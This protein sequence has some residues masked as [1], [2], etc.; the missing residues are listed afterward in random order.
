MQRRFL[1]SDQWLDARHR[2]GLEGELEAMAYLTACGWQLE[3]HRFRVGRHD[4]DL[5]MRRRR[6]VAF[7]EVKTRRSLACGAGVEAVGRRK[8]RIIARVAAV[9]VMRHGYSGDEYRFDVV[10]VRQV[11]RGW[12]VMHVPDAFRPPEC[13][14]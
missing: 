13:L 3:A 9:W 14:I 10:E 7:V 12:A 1:P 2:A 8:Q 11:G 6:T 5:V 4:V